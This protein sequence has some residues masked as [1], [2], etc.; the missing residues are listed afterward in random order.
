MTALI[1]EEIKKFP[2]V[3]MRFQTSYVGLQQDDQKATLLLNDR[4]TEDDYYVT[5]D[6]VVGCDGANSSVRRN[7]CIPFEGV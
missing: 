3:E 6:Y 4:K 7:L 1:A 2:S 5:S